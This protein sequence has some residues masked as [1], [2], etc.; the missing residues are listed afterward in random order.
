MSTR[1]VINLEEVVRDWAW[2]E[3]DAT[4]TSGQKKLRRKDKREPRKYLHVELDW[5]EASFLNETRW[6]PLAV[7]DLDSVTP[8]NITHGL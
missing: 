8:N 1:N 2:R 3:Y 4:A 6:S 5:S 7:D